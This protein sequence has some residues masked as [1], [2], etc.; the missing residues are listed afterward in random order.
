MSFKWSEIRKWAEKN[1]IKPKKV[2]SE[3]QLDNV[4]YKDINEIT[5][6]VFNKITDNKFVEHQKQYDAAQI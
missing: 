1:N 2:G 6:A 5:R 4:I 3:Y